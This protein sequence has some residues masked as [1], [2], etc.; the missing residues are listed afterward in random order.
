MSSIQ[1][2]SRRAPCKPLSPDLAAAIQPAKEAAA[3]LRNRVGRFDIYDVLEA[4]YRVYV[5]WRGR[6]IAK[7]SAHTLADELNMAWRKGMNPM[8]VL[9]EATVSHANSKQKSRWVRALEYVYSQDVPV[10]RFRKFVGRH[11]GLAG[12]AQ[13]A[14]RMNR[15]RRRPRHDCAEGDWED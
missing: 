10:E 12:C 7:L 6:K 15:K 9:I 3:R 1:A 2:T 4:V 11:G 8:R 14:V 13:L 5:H